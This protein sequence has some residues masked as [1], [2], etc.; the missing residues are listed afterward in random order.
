MPLET[1]LLLNGLPQK[2]LQISA[3]DAHVGRAVAL[4]P[5]QQRHLAHHTP[6]ACIAGAQVPGENRNGI[7]RILQTPS[8]Q[9][10]CDIGAELNAR[11]LSGQGGRTL[12]HIY[13][14]ACT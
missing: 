4:R 2:G 9:N 14:G 12:H 5:C 1:T 3:V 13:A 6:I 8:T 7:Q 10:A 11:A